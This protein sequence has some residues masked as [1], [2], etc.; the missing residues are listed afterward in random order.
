MI[1]F[2]EW[3]K[4]NKPLNEFMADFFDKGDGASQNSNVKFVR[5]KRQQ[6][7]DGDRA[8]SIYH[9][10]SAEGILRKRV[11]YRDGLFEL[12]VTGASPWFKDPNQHLTVGYDEPIKWDAEKN[13]WY[14]AADH[15]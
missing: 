6:P 15:D 12:I 4:Q 9:G 13:M 14:A 5:P 3:V 1:S 8:Y 7:K 10:R 2:T 11:G